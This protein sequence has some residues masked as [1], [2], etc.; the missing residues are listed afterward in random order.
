MISLLDQLELLAPLLRRDLLVG[1]DYDGT[2]VPIVDHPAD[3][4][5]SEDTRAALVAVAERY[6]T[7]VISGRSAADLDVRLRDVPVVGRY[8]NH[9]ADLV[10]A[11]PEDLRRVRRWRAALGSALE[12]DGGVE[13]EDKGLSLSVHVRH[14]ADPEEATERVVGLLARIA[15]EAR[16]VPGKAV[17]N[18]VI[19]TRPHKGH[20]L[21]A[22][23]RTSRCSHALFVGDDWTDEDVFA[24]GD[25]TVV[26]VRVGYTPASQATTYLT[27]RDE[28]DRLLEHLARAR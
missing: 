25:P 7:V 20:A 3:A 14:A 10:E 5:M 18:V 22:A 23:M 8:G 15:P 2:L 1:L 27:D 12:G 26:G 17:I 11:D 9:G 24:L 4:R 28:V 16:L 13:I 6:P 21:R 19:A